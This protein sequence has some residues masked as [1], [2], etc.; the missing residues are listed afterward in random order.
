[1]STLWIYQF[2]PLLSAVG[3]QPVALQPIL[4]AGVATTS[5]AMPFR[6]VSGAIR[7]RHACQQAGRLS[8][9]DQQL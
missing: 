6:I 5:T 1:M 8:G 3:Y 4:G 9:F 7:A 2:V